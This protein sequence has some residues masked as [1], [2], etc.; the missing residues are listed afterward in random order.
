MKVRGRCS[1]CDVSALGLPVAA[2][3]AVAVSVQGVRNDV[4]RKP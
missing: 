1:V 4:Q 2:R 3:R